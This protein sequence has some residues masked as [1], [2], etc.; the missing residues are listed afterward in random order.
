MRTPWTPSSADKDHLW[1]NYLDHMEPPKIWT[2]RIIIYLFDSDCDIRI[3]FA[4]V[5]IVTVIPIPWDSVHT[6]L[7]VSRWFRV[8]S[9]RITDKCEFAKLGKRFGFFFNF[10]ENSVSQQANCKYDRTGPN[11]L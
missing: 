11:R 7:I 9:I 8:P 10:F 4:Y 6:P 3:D 2:H 5:L 1:R